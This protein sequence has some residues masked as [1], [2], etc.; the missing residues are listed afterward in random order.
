MAESAAIQN[1]AKKSCPFLGTAFV[2]TF[3]YRGAS[4]M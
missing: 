2:L 1:R 4:I 3:P